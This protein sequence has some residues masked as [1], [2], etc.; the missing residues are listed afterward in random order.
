MNIWMRMH[1]KCSQTTRACIGESGCSLVKCEV[2]TLKRGRLDKLTLHRQPSLVPHSV[3]ETVSEKDSEDDKGDTKKN[4]R[5][6]FN[7]SV[8]ELE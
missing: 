3:T 7:K 1:T 8:T 2:L 5:V 4:K 6:L